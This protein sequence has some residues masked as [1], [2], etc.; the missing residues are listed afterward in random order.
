MLSLSY[1]IIPR[2]IT[3]DEV[4]KTIVIL[5]HLLAFPFPLTTVH[6]LFVLMNVLI[7]NSVR[8]PMFLKTMS[9]CN[10]TLIINVLSR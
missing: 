3:N 4:Y 6:L 7:C 9:R 2:P 1:L 8:T 5:H 10:L